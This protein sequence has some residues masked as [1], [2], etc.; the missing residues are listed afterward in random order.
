MGIS[1]HQHV[2]SQEGGRGPSQQSLP[3]DSQDGVSLAAFTILLIMKCAWSDMCMPESLTGSTSELEALSSEGQKLRT[4]R[5]KNWFHIGFLTL[6]SAFKR[7]SCV[8]CVT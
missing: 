8:L 2:W 3:M 7:W 5:G 4:R 6:A 1:K